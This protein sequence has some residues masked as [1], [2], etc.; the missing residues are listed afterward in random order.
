MKP[1][2]T[3]IILGIATMPMALLCAWLLAKVGA[4]TEWQLALIVFC[5][6][7]GMF[8][9]CLCWAAKTGDA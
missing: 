2:H 5:V 3:C 1:I 7:I 6:F 9:G 4:P 8:T